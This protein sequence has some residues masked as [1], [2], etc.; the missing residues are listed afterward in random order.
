[1]QDNHRAIR[2]AIQLC[3]GLDNFNVIA[4]GLS[5]L[6]KHYVRVGQSR[7]DPSPL[8]T[9]VTRSRDK[10]MTPKEMPD[11]KE[12]QMLFNLTDRANEADARH[13]LASFEWIMTRVHL[14]IFIAK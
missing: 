2:L 10:K 6:A 5:A 3:N 1:M 12:G 4:K 11:S 14:A 13:I 8:A 9:R 7:L